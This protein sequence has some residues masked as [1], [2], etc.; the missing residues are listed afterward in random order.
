MTKMA[1]MSQFGHKLIVL[2]LFV[3]FFLKKRDGRVFDISSNL[4]DCPAQPGYSHYLGPG[5]WAVSHLYTILLKS[6]G[7]QILDHCC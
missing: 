3:Y 4:Q 2:F 1:L 7:F 6:Q 5:G